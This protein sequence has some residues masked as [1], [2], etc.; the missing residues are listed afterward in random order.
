MA[1]HPRRRSTAKTSRP[2]ARAKPATHKVLREVEE[3]LPKDEWDRRGF[4]VDG[5]G[6]VRHGWHAASTWYARIAS[7]WVKVAY[8]CP[9]CQVGRLVVG[10]PLEA[11]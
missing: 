1:R 8:W 10:K 6:R 3:R 7:A 9:E 4:A 5:Q 11:R 2:A